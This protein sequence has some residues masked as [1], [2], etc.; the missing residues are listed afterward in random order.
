MRDEEESESLVI[1]AD[2]HAAVNMSS[3]LIDRERV[4]YPNKHI[5]IMFRRIYVCIEKRV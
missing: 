4:D 3:G 1:A 5:Y 2:Q